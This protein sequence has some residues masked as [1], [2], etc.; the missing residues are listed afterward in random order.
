MSC[1]ALEGIYLAQSIKHNHVVGCIMGNVG[2]SVSRP[3]PIQVTKSQD[4]SA[5][6]PRI[7][8]LFFY[9]SLLNPPTLWRAMLNP[10]SDALIMG[11]HVKCR[12]LHMPIWTS[13]MWGKVNVSGHISPLFNDVASRSTWK[14]TRCRISDAGNIDQACHCNSQYRQHYSL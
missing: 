13:V 7:F 4:I 2:L 9:L 6:A 1:S 14:S 10:W 8:D 5:S 3:W 11:W 12:C